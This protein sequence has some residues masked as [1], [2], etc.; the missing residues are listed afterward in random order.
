MRRIL[1]IMLMGLVLF[2]C[3][4]EGYHPMTHT[5]RA[6]PVPADQGGLYDGT[7]NLTKG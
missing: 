2:S 5:K 4:S 1:L 7:W 3:L 6:K